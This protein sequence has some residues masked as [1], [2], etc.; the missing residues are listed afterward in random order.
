VQEEALRERRL[1][2]GEGMHEHA[3]VAHRV[4]V[5]VDE[6]A[7][8]HVRRVAAAVVRVAVVL[9]AIAEEGRVRDAPSSERPVAMSTR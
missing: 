3:A 2:I 9:D 4:D 1:E 5:F 8:T 6:E 7:A